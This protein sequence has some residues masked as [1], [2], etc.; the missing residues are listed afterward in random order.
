MNDADGVRA[1][2]PFFQYSEKKTVTCEWMGKT[3][4]RIMFATIIERE[5]YVDDNCATFSCDCEIR[6]ALNRAYEND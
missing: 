1:V 5:R 2:C 3:K 6:R 4:I